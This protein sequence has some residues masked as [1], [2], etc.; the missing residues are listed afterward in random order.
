[1]KKKRTKKIKEVTKQEIAPVNVYGESI[2]FATDQFR[3]GTSEKTIVDALM[4]THPIFKPENIQ[5][6][7]NRASL[8]IA[9]EYARDRGSIAALHV[10]RYNKEFNKEFS[11]EHHGIEN[12][13]FRRQKKIESLNVC[14]DALFAKE[15]VLQIHAKET[16]VKIF[17]RMNAKIKMRKTSYDLSSLTFQEKLEF[18]QLV[19]KAKRTDNELFSVA[20]KPKENVKTEDAEVIEIV[21]TNVDLIQQTNHPIPEPELLPNVTKDSVIAKLRLALQKSADRD[22]KAK[23]AKDNTDVN[24][25]D[26]RKET[27]K[28]ERNGM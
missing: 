28:L 17:N 3:A 4:V 27:L 9:N 20:L 13:I 14:L 24:V 1:M 2:A 10:R 7:I 11:N 8:E 21:N 26:L 5:F 15:R 12:P 16:Q 22:F 6:I 19:S 23:G 18:L 25:T